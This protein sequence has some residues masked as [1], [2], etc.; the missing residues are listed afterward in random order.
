M[1]EPGAGGDTLGVALSVAT[2]GCC[3]LYTVLARR[4]LVDDASLTV[5]A[6][7]QAAALVFA[8]ALLAG[9]QL[10]SPGA[11]L[12]SVPTTTWLWA[13]LSGLLYY[14]AAFWLYLAGLGQVSAAVAGSFLPLVPV[15][16]VATA[17][18]IGEQL[19]GRQWL[20][21]AVVVSAVVVIASWQARPLLHP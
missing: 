5:A 9:S 16:G 3:A 12:T 11:G 19:S 21:A 18:T 14:G 1:Y 15:F 6:V 13:A 8:L 2:V 20:G 10:I 17:L 4:L 7:Q